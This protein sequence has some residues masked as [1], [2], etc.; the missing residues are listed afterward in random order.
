MHQALTIYPRSLCPAVA[1]IDVEVARP[2]PG[3]LVLNYAVT[4]AMRDLWLPAEAAPLRADELW[5][6]TCFEVFVRAMAGEAYVE[7]NVSPSRQW[8]AYRFTGYRV[9]MRP[10]GEIPP[11]AIE[12]RAADD[13]LELDVSL[14]LGP[15]PE[16]TGASPWRLGLAAVIEE[17]N[18]RTSYW[19]LAHPPG[20]PDFHAADGFAY[21]LPLAAE[22]S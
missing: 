19:A 17:A 7:V 6:R 16:L 18:G 10:A 12:V 2:R 4:G 15:L 14:D 1:S 13:R 5:R 21:N 9:G 3:R 22:A 20:K 11:P 8:A